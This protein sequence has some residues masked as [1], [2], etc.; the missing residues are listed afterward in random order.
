[1][2]AAQAIA[3]MKCFTAPMEF[4]T[5]FMRLTQEALVKSTLAGEESLAIAAPKPPQV[6]PAARWWNEHPPLNQYSTILWQEE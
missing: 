6:G 4:T 2:R 1:M 3:L 5:S